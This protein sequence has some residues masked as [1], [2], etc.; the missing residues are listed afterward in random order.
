MSTSGETDSTHIKKS[1]PWRKAHTSLASQRGPACAPKSFLTS[2]CKACEPNLQHGPQSDLSHHQLHHPCESHHHL[3]EKL[4]Q[5]EVENPLSIVR[6][7]RTPRTLCSLQKTLNQSREK[8]LLMILKKND[9]YRLS[10]KLLGTTLIW[11]HWLQLTRPQ[12]TLAQGKKDSL[13]CVAGKAGNVTGS[14]DL[15]N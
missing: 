3:K 12:H 1:K 15:R 14:E 7:N 6:H 2:P 8:R 10:R 11:S 5:I 13:V 4:V 9:F